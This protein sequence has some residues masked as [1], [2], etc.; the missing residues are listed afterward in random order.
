MKRTRT[1]H[2]VAGTLVF[3]VAGLVYAWSTFSLSISQEYPHW[4]QAQLSLTYSLVWIF[5]CVG[6][7]LSALIAGK[8]KPITILMSCGVLFLISFLL[9]ANAHSLPMLYLS[10][11]I[12]G[13]LLTGIV[14]NT[15]IVAV[16]LWFPDRPGLC[17]GI[18]LSGFGFSSFLIGNAYQ[19]FTPPEIGAWRTSF[20][21]LGIVVCAIICLCALVIR[22]PGPDFQMEATAKKH[23]AADH[24]TAQMMKTPKFWVYYLWG[25]LFVGCGSGLVAHAS[26]IAME[27]SAAISPATVALAASLISVCNGGFR[28]V[29]GAIFDRYG[30]KSDM[31][32]IATGYLLAASLL[33]VALKTACFPLAVAGFLLCGTMY[34]GMAPCAAG[35][36]GS[37]F[38]KKHYSINFSVFNT[39]MIPAS[40]GSTLAGAMYD[41]TGSYIPFCYTI[42]V[43]ALVGYGLIVTLSAL[44]RRKV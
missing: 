8:L 6:G 28:S 14:Y 29:F 35:F 33:V 38:G 19:A 31:V 37:N 7:I 11:G 10:F 27:S 18:M 9:A 20:V 26:R 44:E 1:L 4:T 41:T 43:C 5:F 34:G 15:A 3:L 24:T 21:V 22:R 30:L 42:L 32:I 25:V 40:L 2:L 12:L 16:S 36:V 13:G 39:S 23:F 17:N